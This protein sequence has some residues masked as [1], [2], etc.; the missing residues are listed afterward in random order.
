MGDMI[1]FGDDNSALFLDSGGDRV[2]A[3]IVFSLCVHLCLS[4]GLSLSQV[5]YVLH[6]IINI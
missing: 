5:F 3:I 6:F 2:I 4:L 1:G